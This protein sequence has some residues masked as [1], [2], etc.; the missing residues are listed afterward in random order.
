MSSLFRKEVKEFNSYV[1]GKSI[2]EV[3]QKYGLEEVIKLASN[4]NPL[5]PSPMA[6]EA[7]RNAL[8]QSNR[9]PDPMSTKLR[10]SLARKFRLKEE[11]IVVGNGAE[12]IL[13][14]IADTFVNAGDEAIMADPS[15]DIYAHSVQFLGGNA[16]KVPLVNHEYDLNGIADAINV[17]TKLLYLCNP[18]NPTGNIITKNKLDCLLSNIPENIV[19]ILDEA[20]YEYACIHQDYPNGLDILEKRENTIV[21]RT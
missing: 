21:V 6:V 12:Q 10:I 18:N 11:Q 13:L 16:V 1:P 14:L 9:Y 17:R 2:E 7:A 3:K 19:I 5:G 4:E 20:Y 8:D 15:F